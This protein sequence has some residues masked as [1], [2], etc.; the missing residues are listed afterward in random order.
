MKDQ[1]VRA[2]AYLSFATTAGNTHLVKELKL[3]I[4]EV[5]RAMGEARKDSELSRG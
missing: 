2:R 3:R 5:E 4:K 1:V